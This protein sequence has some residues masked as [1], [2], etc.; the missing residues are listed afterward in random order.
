EAAGSGE[1]VCLAECGSDA[2][3][4]ALG[5]ALTCVGGQ[6]VPEAPA[7][8]DEDGD[9]LTTC[10]GDCDDTNADVA[11]QEVCADGLDNDCDGLVDEGCDNPN[12]CASDS[13]CPADAVCTPTG[14]CEPTQEPRLCDADG[15]CPAGWVCTPA[16]ICEPEDPSQCGE[17]EV[18]ADGLDNDCDGFID[19]GCTPDDDDSDRIP[20]ADDNCPQ[21]FN[22][23]QSDADGDGWG[24]VCDCGMFDS[25]ISPIATEVCRDAIDNDCD[26]LIDEDC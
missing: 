26:G 21:A 19:E 15:A 7:C 24:D 9:G 6:C 18:C 14:T 11:L 23:D 1:G 17:A 10:G 25:D 3:C 8:P 13:D 4:T 12:T 16:G 2:D 20:N 5:D 22:P